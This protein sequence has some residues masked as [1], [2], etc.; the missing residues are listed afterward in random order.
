M[1]KKMNRIMMR[2]YGVV[3]LMSLLLAGCGSSDE[4]VSKPGSVKPAITKAELSSGTNPLVVF[5]S[6]SGKTKTVAQKLS[7]SLFCNI[8]EIVSK[9]DRQGFGGIMTCVFDQIFHRYDEIEKVSGDFSECNPIIIVS[10]VWIHKVSSPVR[11]FIKDTSLRGKDVFL[12]LTYNGSLKE[13]DEQKI[14]SWIEAYGINLKGIFKIITKK[15]E[16]G[17]LEKESGQLAAG[18]GIKV[19]ETI[20]E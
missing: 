14:K 16:V 3:L 18:F 11:T 7:D 2:C 19:L 13:K 8:S 12:V 9:K 10:P 4:P 20:A 15:K 1:F 6:R 17:D 5:Y